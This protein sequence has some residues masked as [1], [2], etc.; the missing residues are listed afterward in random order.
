M[1]LSSSLCGNT[2]LPAKSIDRHLPVTPCFRI[3]WWDQQPV[4]FLARGPSVLDSEP[5][6]EQAHTRF[7]FFVGSEAEPL[8]LSASTD[9][10]GTAV[11]LWYQNRDSGSG[12]VM[13]GCAWGHFLLCVFLNYIQGEMD[14]CVWAFTA[15]THAVTVKVHCRSDTGHFLL[16]LHS[17]NHS[18][19]AQTLVQWEPIHQ[20]STGQVWVFAGKYRFTR[21]KSSTLVV[22]L[23]CVS[24]RLWKWQ[25]NSWYSCV[26]VSRFLTY[27][28]SPRLDDDGTPAASLLLNLG[29]AFL[30]LLV[31]VVCGTYCNL[32]LDPTQTI[33]LNAPF[34][35]KTKRRWWERKTENGQKFELEKIPLESLLLEMGNKTLVIHLNESYFKVLQQC[36]YNIKY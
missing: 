20:Q 25:T 13:C 34:T 12:C 3:T 5:H 14:Q 1:I 8:R 29:H 7:L 27:V 17:D 6:G 18:E 36:I 2:K 26:I 11:R 28:S 30:G 21:T 24:R 4:C 32:V 23:V 9:T 35:A 31:G 19:E 16:T 33:Q 15:S 10:Q 22:L